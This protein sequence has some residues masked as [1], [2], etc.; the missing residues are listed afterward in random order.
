MNPHRI[1]FIIIV[2][3]LYFLSSTSEMIPD[4]SSLLKQAQL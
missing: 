2:S 4:I 3:V 1:F